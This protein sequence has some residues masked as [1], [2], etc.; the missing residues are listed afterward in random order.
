MPALKPYTRFN[1]ILRREDYLHDVLLVQQRL[2]EL[3]YLNENYNGYYGKDT[4]SAV[5]AFQ[6]ANG[7][8]ADGLCGQATWD[9]LFGNS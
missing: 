7:L 3:G 2:S 4:E 6:Q 5:R 1:Q 9:A 8:Q